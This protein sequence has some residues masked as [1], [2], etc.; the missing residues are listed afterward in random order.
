MVLWCHL[1]GQLW[2]KGTFKNGKKDG[3]YVEYHDNGHLTVKGTYKDGKEDGPWVGFNKDGTVWLK[4]TGTFK[5][6]VKVSD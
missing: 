5:N 3:P 4:Y 2:F 6:G 1:N